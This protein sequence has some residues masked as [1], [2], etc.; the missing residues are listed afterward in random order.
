MARAQ[1]SPAEAAV[2]ACRSS[3]RLKGVIFM[4][5]SPSL[6]LIE[7]DRRRGRLCEDCRVKGKPQARRMLPRRMLL[8]VDARDKRGHDGV[9]WTAVVLMIRVKI[10]N[11]HADVT[12]HSGGARSH[13]SR[14]SFVMAGLVPAKIGRAH[15]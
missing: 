8:S 3:G 4:A 15:V 7:R 10:S 2:E 9:G 13:Q 11:S 5:A 1:I 12:P 14:S 6:F